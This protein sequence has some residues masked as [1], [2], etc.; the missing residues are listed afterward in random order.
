ML[1]NRAALSAER[2]RGSEA[3]NQGQDARKKDARLE[4]R[5]ARWPLPQLPDVNGR[6]IGK[7]K[8]AKTIAVVMA[9]MTNP[10]MVPAGA[11]LFV[12]GKPSELAT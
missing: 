12:V 9:Y 6:L 1:A 2:K 3:S 8:S 10:H 11:R 4:Y 5:E 7:R